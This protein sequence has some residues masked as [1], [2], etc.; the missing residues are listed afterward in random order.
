MTK[1]GDKKDCLKCGTSQSAV[2][3]RTT[4]DAAFVAPGGAHPERVPDQY[5]WICAECGD[6]ERVK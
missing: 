6:Q 3:T 1:V 4:S 5:A 2:Y